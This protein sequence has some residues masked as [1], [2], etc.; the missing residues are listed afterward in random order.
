MAALVPP[1]RLNL[2]RYHGV[3]APNAADRVRI[4]PGPK[5]EACEA[6]PGPDAELT[7]AQRSHRVAWA[8]LL[9]RV[10]RVDV[11]QCPA[12]GGH[13]KIIAALTDSRSIQA[14]L[15]GVGLPSR[16][17]PIAPAPPH[18]QHELDY[19]A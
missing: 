17:P 15:E 5:E 11:T 12:C 2:V 10:F 16:A 1:P 3:L 4:V 18:P 7:P 8:A 19:A 13:M 6:A 14:Y 9:R